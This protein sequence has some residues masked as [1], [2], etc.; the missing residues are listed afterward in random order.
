MFKQWRWRWRGRL[1]TI[2]F[3][4]FG[5]GASL[6]F[7]RSERER[8]R[9]ILLRLEDHRVLH[10][11]YELEEEDG[12]W[13]SIEALRAYLNEQVEQCES[14]EL[15]EQVR[16][17]RAAVRQWLTDV[18][19][20]RR[21]AERTQ[22]NASP[23]DRDRMQWTLGLQALGLLRGRVGVAVA[24]IGRKFDI[25]IDG[26]LA[27]VTPPDADASERGARLSPLYFDDRD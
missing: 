14:E 18:E 9:S 11:P 12:T 1:Q 17:M 3:S 25:P 8:A 13:G 19:S 24:E 15:R 27:H 5:Q 10:A 26:D 2:S 7:T 23:R 20:A 6:E 22:G 21:F 16:A 4:F